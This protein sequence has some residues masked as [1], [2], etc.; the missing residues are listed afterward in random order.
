[1]SVSMFSKSREIKLMYLFPSHL[2]IS[3]N[4]LKYSLEIGKRMVF[5]LLQPENMEFI[6][7][8]LLV[9]NMETLREVKL[10]QLLIIAFI[11]LTFS[12]LNISLVV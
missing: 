9:L 12:V 8:T 3:K 6:S 10:E 2:Y 11:V 7:V 5:S 1:M 4:L